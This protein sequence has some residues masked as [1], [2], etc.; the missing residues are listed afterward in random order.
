MTDKMAPFRELL[1]PKSPFNWDNELYEL[2]IASK[3]KILEEIE[4]G[5]Q[6]FDKSKPTCLATDWS[7]TG[8]GFWLFQKHCECSGRTLFCCHEGWKVALVGSRFT[9]PAESR[10]APVEGEALAVVAARDKSRHFVLG[11]SDLIVA[12]DHKPLLGLFTNRSLDSIPNNRL[13]NLKERTLRYRFTMIH[14]PGLKNRAPDALSR[15]PTGDPKPPL[16]TLPDD[17]SYVSAASALNSLRSTTWDEIR[18]ET[19]SDADMKT[20]VE[21]I[22]SGMTEYRNDLPPR[23]RIY[24]QHREHLSTTDGVALYGDRIIVPPRLRSTI[25]SSLHAAH[26]GITSMTLRAESSV[27]WPGITSD[28]AKLR[29]GCSS[30]DRIAPSQQN[31]PPT[32]IQYPDYPF[33]QV[34]G[35]FF[36]YKGHY[37]LVCVDRYSNWPIVEEA[38]HGASGLVDCLRRTF[39]TYGIPNEFSSDGGPELSASST[40]TF[41]KNWGVNRRVSSVSFPHSNCRAEVGV[42]TVKRMLMDNTGTSGDLNTD[43]FQRAI[44]QYRNTP[45]QTTKLSPAICLFGRPIRDF[46]PILPGKYLP[47]LTWRSVLQDREVALRRRHMAVAERLTLNSKR[48]PP[49]RVGDNVRIQNQ[50][51][52]YP[53]RWERTGTVIEV[54]QHDQYVIRVDGSRR[55]TLRN[56]KFLRRFTPVQRNIPLGLLVHTSIHTDRQTKDRSQNT[57][58]ITAEVPHP[59]ESTHTSYLPP[60]PVTHDT[61][62]APVTAPVN[63]DGPVEVLRIPP[64][65]PLVVPPSP[66]MLRRSTRDRRPPS[67]LDD[68]IVGAP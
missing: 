61:Y 11:C 38:R 14:V 26:H 30:C 45:N 57:Q 56:R 29:Q 66:P 2:F 23:L 5:V 63:A 40:V 17:I 12:V 15:H 10:Y 36:H 43:E 58:P 34:C 67:R 22:E 55:V 50:T 3:L 18:L 48:L 1:K 60:V 41:L 16:L 54:R 39:V 8:I 7:K 59:E 24:H 9:H 53:R 52:L 64:S 33:Q 42:K 37:Y 13:R 68:F 44:L 4:R 47:H 28:I 65:P 32:P 46:I 51:G 20:L 27:F 31:S 6:I 25:L 35:D 49:L 19:T 21:I 62:T